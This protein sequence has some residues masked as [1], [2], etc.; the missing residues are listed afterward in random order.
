MECL[1][2]KKVTVL[3]SEYPDVDLWKLLSALMENG[4]KH[5][6][7]RFGAWSDY[8]D[9]T[10]RGLGENELRRSFSQCASAECKTLYMG[11]LF[12][13][14]RSAHGH[15]LGIIDGDQNDFVDIISVPKENLRK[16]IK[17]LYSTRYIQACN[18]CNPIWA[19][20]DIKCGEQL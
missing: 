6:I 1:K 12:A 3:I 7:I 16:K 20:G 18:H 19:R 5:K 2:N 15:S 4:I 13:C 14:P 9:T 10:P 17:T 8:G 11:K